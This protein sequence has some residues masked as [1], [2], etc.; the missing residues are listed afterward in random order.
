MKKALLMLLVLAS[1]GTIAGCTSSATS[2]TSADYE[3]VAWDVASIVPEDYGITQEMQDLRAEPNWSE[4]TLAELCAYRLCTDGAGGEL[5]S[6]VLAERFMEA[7][8]T[9]LNYL[10]MLGNHPEAVE[11]LCSGIAWFAP[12]KEALGQTLEQCQA[13]YP[14]GRVSE[15]LAFLKSEH[16]AAMKQH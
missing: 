13:L 11:R 16:E 1:V 8:N 9:V 14:S 5:A 12:S 2:G 6:T 3:V 15:I 7:P 4:L 10:A